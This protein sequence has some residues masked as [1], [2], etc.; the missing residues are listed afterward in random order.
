MINQGRPRH[1]AAAPAAAPQPSD[2]T[3]QPA[4]HSTPPNAAAVGAGAVVSPAAPS[5]ATAQPPPNQAAAAV[6][7]PSDGLAGSQQT[8]HQALGSSS[9]VSGSS[10]SSRLIT[11][12]DYYED[13][14]F[15][16]VNQCV[17]RVVRHKGDYAAVVLLD[18][19]WVAGPAEWAAICS[20]GVGSSSRRKVPV[21][22]L[23]G[24]LQR[25]YV[26]TNGDFGPALKQLA[27]FYKRQV[28]P[29]AAQPL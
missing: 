20:S 5:A 18:S 2:T 13:L 10:C 29:A 12:R 8:N 26:A 23:P 4:Q 1:P 11:G 28:Q 6:S 19:R 15:K 25:S 7:N 16:A 14:C 21:Q 24:W 9:A 17:G 27:A 22:K 3:K